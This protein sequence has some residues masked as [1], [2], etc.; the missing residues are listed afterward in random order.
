MKD[1]ITLVERY[2]FDVI[3]VIVP[4]FVATVIYIVIARGDTYSDILS[5]F[6]KIENKTLI[7]VAILVLLYILGML[8]KVVAIKTY[9]VLGNCMG[10]SREVS[11]PR[12]FSLLTSV[13]TGWKKKILE[14]SWGS[15]SNHRICYWI[16]NHIIMF[17]LKIILRI[18]IG[19]IVV[20]SRL[21]ETVTTFKTNRC[22]QEYEE[23]YVEL[24]KEM[25]KQNIYNFNEDVDI[26][27]DAFRVYKLSS[28]IIRQ[29]ELKAL[30]DNFLAKYNLFRSLALVFGVSGLYS[31][32][33]SAGDNYLVP[34]CLL[35]L[36]FVFHY[37]FIR[38]WDL[39]G[40]DA[41]STVLVYLKN[42]KQE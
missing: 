35:L 7:C 2:L 13:L 6:D 20:V 16:L 1:F 31:M 32:I 39:C 9:D 22:S 27:V 10:N 26:E 41:V 23:L 29:Y 8:I 17:S 4:G 15:N 5:M 37:K 36:W 18:I 40:G 12:L 38:Y 42:K 19:V 14:K 11:I 34:I 24:R 3:G 30:F 25:K 33:I 21:A 28:V